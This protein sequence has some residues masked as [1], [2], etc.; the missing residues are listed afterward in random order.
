MPFHRIDIHEFKRLLDDWFPNRRRSIIEVHMHHT[1]GPNLAVFEGRASIEEMWRRD[2]EEK[3]WSDIAQHVTIDPEGMIWTGRHWDAPP[4]SASGR[5][6]DAKAGP[7][8]VSVVGDFDDGKETF[9]GVQREAT[10]RVIAL[11]QDRFELAPESMQ[12][13]NML[14]TS[15]TCP[16]SGISYPEIV[17]AVRAFRGTAL[18]RARRSQSGP[19]RTALRDWLGA[20]PQIDAHIHLHEPNCCKLAPRDS[21]MRGREL[22]PDI[23][24]PHV[25]N[26]WNGRFSSGGAYSSSAEQVTRIFSHHLPAALHSLPA[27]KTLPIVLYAHGGL[28]SEE[29]GLHIA[30]N[31]IPWWK[32]CGVYPIHFT[33]ETGLLE[34]ILRFFSVTRVTRDLPDISDAIV[35]TAVRTGGG[36]AIWGKMKESASSAF[37]PGAAGTF[38]LEHLAR[39]VAAFAAR[40][41]V[42]AIGHSAGSIFHAHLLQRM[43]ALNAPAL[44]AIYF[45]APAITVDAYSRLIDPLVGDTVKRVDVF[46]MSDTPERDDTVTFAYRKS[47]LYLIHN[48]LEAEP[49]EP[50]LGLER[51]LRGNA[52]LARRF[53]LNGSSATGSVVFSPTQATT[54]MSASRSDTHGGFDN[55]PP[56]MESIARRILHVADGAQLPAPF[57][58]DTESR[59]VATLEKEPFF[60][61]GEIPMTSDTKM[62]GRRAALCI[63]INEYSHPDDRLSGCV[64]DAQEWEAALK[65]LGFEV[66]A[67][68]DSRATKRHIIEE[69]G[70]MIAN[71]QAGDALVLQYSGHGTFVP[72]QD[73]DDEGGK[74]EA[75]CPVDYDTGELLVDDEIRAELEKLPQ[76]VQLTMFMDNC[77]SYSN[78]RFALGRVLE[79]S[80]NSKPRFVKLRRSVLDRYLEMRRGSRRTRAFSRGGTQEEMRWVSFSACKDNE[81]AWE[82][83]GRGDY[84]RIA[85]PL[86]SQAGLTNRAFNEAVIA[87]FGANPRQTPMLDCPVAMK[88]S[89]LLAGAKSGGA[90]ALKPELLGSSS[91]HRASAVADMLEAIA[92][93]IR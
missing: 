10:L 21:A 38:V 44:D 54:G 9:D 90:V 81:L 57:P 72:D 86:L 12:F 80:A 61:Q 56:T 68:H 8:M 52:T 39:F 64:A 89:E 16:G 66:Q 43:Q 75:I 84:S 25:I 87:G 45:L 19:S 35:E 49:G 24:Q 3:G 37:E 1:W 50:V 58:P 77:Y 91:A 26:I 47:L 13:H 15:K 69:L 62:A 79:P 48:A 73:G 53:G 4:A 71:S 40:V 31:Q 33:W 30:Q 32:A 74:D 28:V 46:T 29:A 7:F 22:D 20:A 34:T 85:I 70:K 11:V 14:G 36:G 78:G 23:L 17:V 55:D 59:S 63:G 60:L 42:Y 18:P 92:R 76:N 88:Q 65:R 83:N 27:G 93:V 51:S 5:N 6:G 82:T 2:T 67:L 41:K